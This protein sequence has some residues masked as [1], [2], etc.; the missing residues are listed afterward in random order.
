MFFELVDDEMLDPDTA[1]KMSES[2]IGELEKC[3]E[4]DKTEL[5]QVCKQLV[6]E[7]KNGLNRA[8]VIGFLEGLDENYLPNY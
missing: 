1:L 8:E 5:F 7:E 3:D 2:I 6:L 4:K